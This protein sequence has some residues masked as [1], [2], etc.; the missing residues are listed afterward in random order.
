MSRAPIVVFGFNRPKH[1]KSCLDSLEAAHGAHE[2]DLFV[3]IDGPRSTDDTSLMK[4]CHVVA[5]APRT[6]KSTTLFLRDTNIGLSLSIRTGIDRVMETHERVIVVEDDLLVDAGFLLFMNEALE[7]YK[8]AWRVASIHGYTYPFTRDMESSFFLRGADCWGWA[9][10]QDRWASADFDGIRLYKGLVEADLVND[11]DFG[12][13]YDYSW[14]LRR[15][16]LG[17]NDSWAV[18]WHASMF[19]QN[20]LTLY[21]PKSLVINVGADGSGSN[22]GVS[23]TYDTTLSEFTEWNFPSKVEES[24]EARRALQEFFHSQNNTSKRRRI[25]HRLQRFFDSIA[26]VIVLFLKKFRQ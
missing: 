26:L 4:A 25:Y 5:Q 12:G 3:F 1:L 10:W 22:S 9:T 20:R 8:A 13:E 17:K 2:S 16:I 11:F 6:F 15:Q 23:N 7:K 21:P 14:M 18:R 24:N 19:L